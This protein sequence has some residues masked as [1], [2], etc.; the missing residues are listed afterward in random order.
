[1]GKMRVLLKTIK[2]IDTESATRYG[3]FINPAMEDYFG[4]M[5]EVEP[6]TYINPKDY[7]YVDVAGWGYKK[8]WIVWDHDLLKALRRCLDRE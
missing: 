3:G 4:K 5:I 7:Q 1:M 2:Q 6:S 8:E